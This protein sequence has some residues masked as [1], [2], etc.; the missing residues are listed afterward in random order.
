MK[1]LFYVTF[2][3]NVAMELS[4]HSHG[5]TSPSKEINIIIEAIQVGI[6]QPHISEAALTFELFCPED[7]LIILLRYFAKYNRPQMPPVPERARRAY[8]EIFDLG[9][10]VLHAPRIAL[11][12]FLEIPSTAWAADVY[13]ECKERLARYNHFLEDF[14]SWGPLNLKQLGAKLVKVHKLD[15]THC[16]RLP[17]YAYPEMQMWAEGLLAEYKKP[18]CFP[19]AKEFLGHIR[20]LFADWFDVDSIASHYSYGFDFYVTRDTHGIFSSKHRKRLKE[21]YG[22]LILHPSELVNEI[23]QC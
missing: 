2:D 9:F 20:K 17:G 14:G 13:F 1:G 7:R 3:T 6:I 19:S 18:M 11:K 15:T 8:Q 12:S 22:V 4:A 21:K 16:P 5:S 10:R 23:S